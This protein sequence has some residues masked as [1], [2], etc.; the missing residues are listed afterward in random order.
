[1]LHRAVRWSLPLLLLLF[2]LPAAAQEPAP[3]PALMVKVGEASEPL[4]VRKV[5]VDV[6][7][8]GHLAETRMTM[9]FYNPHSRALAGDLYFPLPEGATVSGYALDVSGVLVDGVVV[10]KEAARRA[11]EAEVRRG[12][13]P[14]LV[15][16]VGGNNFRTRVFP[17]PAQGTRTV[18]VAYVA[19]LVDG[20]TGARYQLPLDFRQKLGEFRIRLEVVR[21]VAAPRVVAG[22][23]EGLNF[24]AWRDSFVAEAE[25]TDFTP[26]DTLVVEL[27]EIEKTPV[28]VERAPDGTVYFAIRDSPPSLR[29]EPAALPGRIRLLWDASLSRAGQSHDRELALLRAYLDKGL[30]TAAVTVDLVVFRNEAEPAVS[31][32]LP[33]QKDDLFRALAGVAYD[34]GTQMA[35]ISPAADAPRVDLILLFTDGLSNF[36]HSEPAIEGAPVYVFNAAPTANHDFLRYLALR[37][38][39]TYFNLGRLED[40]LVVGHIGQP[41]YSLLRAKVTSGSAAEI[42]PQMPR[43]VQGAMTVAGQLT[44][45]T[46][47]VTLEYGIGSEVLQRRRITVRLA[48]AVPGDL[49]RIDWAQ[50]SIEDLLIR[51]EENAAA[52]VALGKAQRLVTPGTSLIVM[53]RLEQYVEHRI[54]PPASLAEMQADYDRQVAALDAAKA[55]EQASKLAQVLELW[56][57]RIAWWEQTFSYPAGFRYREAGGEGSAETEASTG[58]ARD[59]RPRPAASP[60]PEAVSREMA[61]EPAEAHGEEVAKKADAAG[62]GPDPEPAVV[63]KPWDPETPYLAALKAASPADRYGEYLRQRESF[64]SSPAFFLDC[65]DFFRKNDEPALALRILSSVAE[66][67]LEDPALLRVLAHRLAQLDLLDLSVLLFEEVLRLRPEEPQSYRDL[68][69]VI[70]RRALAGGDPETARADYARAMELLARVVMDRWDRFSEIEVIA[71][72]ELNGILPRA[73]AAGVT[74]P[75][76]DD[77]LLRHLDVDIR[78]V[79]TWD[80]DMTDMDLHVVEPS[81]EVAFYS[82]NRTTIGGM[83]TRDFTQ[84]YGPE[85][86]LLRKAMHGTYQIKAK[87][88]GSSAAELVGA[89][90]LQVDVYTNYG[91]PNERRQ[92]MTFRLTEAKEMFTVGEIEF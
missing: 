10:E 38:G 4:Q 76:V 17:L 68:A 56:R 45:D 15:E 82:H 36:G 73:K 26:R 19:P 29:M 61:D 70:A 24:G 37:S 47:E 14:G 89:V 71:L 80:A 23:V 55:R 9:T 16:W 57:A 25:K 58:E 7:V 64:G 3:P 78:I 62:G 59:D 60:P 50:K 84:G 28:R 33:R 49:L 30:G 90:T 2:A 48:D 86:Y 85:V 43:A 69:L 79:M 18:R 5:E 13:D 32:A 42:R 72:M 81:G 39:G 67:R 46:A 66:L 8:L 1:M 75:P 54:R 63:L 74:E 77:R 52:L 41:V 83:V 91:R 87:F 40:E 34:G 6:R 51:P 44:G 88:Y 22:G 20:R 12:V 35:A 27:P 31:F 65:S 53:E 92:S 11:F 21:P